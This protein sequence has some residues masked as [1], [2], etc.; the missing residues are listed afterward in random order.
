MCGF[1]EA[2]IEKSESI[3]NWIKLSLLGRELSTMS[4][5]QGASG[6]RDE[7]LSPSPITGFD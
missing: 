4:S 2:K 5:S 3:M 6:K 7:K 1:T